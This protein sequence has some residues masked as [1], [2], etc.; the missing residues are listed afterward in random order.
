MNNLI[1][2]VFVILSPTNEIL[3]VL[4][5]GDEQKKKELMIG[6]IKTKIDKIAV[7]SLTPA[8]VESSQFIL[9]IVAPLSVQLCTSENKIP[10]QLLQAF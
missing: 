5:Q 10:L 6:I 7:N 1:I 4:G 9:Q 2:I 3:G 8:A